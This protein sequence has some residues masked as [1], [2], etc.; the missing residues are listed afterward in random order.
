[1]DTVAIYNQT[2]S[3][4]DSDQDKGNPTLNGKKDQKLDI[5]TETRDNAHMMQLST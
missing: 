2:Q 3:I 5:Q 1:M 4:H